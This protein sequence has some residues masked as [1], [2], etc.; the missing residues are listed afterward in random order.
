M[1]PGRHFETA[2]LPHLDAAHNLARWL[3]RDAAAAED[4]VQEAA[5]RAL[6]Y[7]GSLRAG[8]D[9]RPW[10]LAIVRNCCFSALER[11][12]AEPGALDDDEW[13]A[14]PG[15]AHEPTQALD[16]RR[17]REAVD[18]AIAALPPLLREMI[19]LR[20]LE[21]LDYR[22]IAQVAGVPIG[23]VMSRLSRGRARLKELLTLAGWP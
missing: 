14:L 22:S 19:V 20:E 7:L 13:E 15:S 21:E 16:R 8:E 1:T 6:R 11:R 18:A 3:L 4:A 9:A 5:L 23:T 10:F 12:G 2:V 17:E